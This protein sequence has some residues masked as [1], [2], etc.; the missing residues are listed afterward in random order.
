MNLSSHFTNEVLQLCEQNDIAFVCLPKNSTH[1]T[2]PLDVGFFRPFKLAW[3]TIL[4]NWKTAH[5]LPAS[6]DKRDFPQLL[7]ATLSE[8][9]KKSDEDAIKKDLISSFKAAGIVPLDPDHVL[10]RIP[11]ENNTVP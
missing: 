4:S 9:N 8:M 7:A 10:H 2:Q 5:K 6:I 3:R 11:S 1:L